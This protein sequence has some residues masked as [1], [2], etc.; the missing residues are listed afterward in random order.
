MTSEAPRRLRAH[1]AAM[2]VSLCLGWRV[3]SSAR[4]STDPL[5]LR[6]CRT[7]RHQLSLADSGRDY[8]TGSSLQTR[9]ARRVAREAT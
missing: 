4:L 7:G 3:W 5:P 9:V 1:E 2:S 8:N 6:L